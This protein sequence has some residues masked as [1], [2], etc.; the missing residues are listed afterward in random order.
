[1]A[2]EDTLSSIL[3]EIDFYLAADSPVD[4]AAIESLANAYVALKTAPFGLAGRQRRSASGVSSR[5]S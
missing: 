3:R 4:A 2:S 1:M 5:T